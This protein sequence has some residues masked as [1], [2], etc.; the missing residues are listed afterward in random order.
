MTRSLDALS[1]ACADPVR[2]VLEQCA[3]EGLEMRPYVTVR[4]PLEQA[5]LWRQSRTRREIDT[6]LALWQRLGLDYLAAVL[7]QAGPQYGP[8]VTQAKPGFSWHQWGEAVDCVWIVGG[9]AV[10]SAQP[11]R[12]RDRNGYRRYTEHAIAAGLTAGG[13]W[14]QR[15]WPHLQLRPE[16]GPHDWPFPRINDTMRERFPL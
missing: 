5:K 7:E 15:D 3:A 6:L 16:R 10:W 4:T 9:A 11:G 8:E 2:R 13:V 1:P 12:T 14:K